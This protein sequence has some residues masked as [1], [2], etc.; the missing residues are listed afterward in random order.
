VVLT[1]PVIETAHYISALLR[2]NQFNTRAKRNGKVMSVSTKNIV[3]WQIGRQ[4]QSA[5]RW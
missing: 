2:H 5:V 3:F 4:Q 1:V